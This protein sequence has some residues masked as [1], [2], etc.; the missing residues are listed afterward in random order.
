[1]YRFTNSAISCQDNL[2]RAS[3]QKYEMPR[4][5]VL[6]NVSQLTQS[7]QGPGGPGGGGGGGNGKGGVRGDGG[8]GANSK[9]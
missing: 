3:K 9:R 7:G 8:H 6:G 4:V 2:N 1:M 5:T